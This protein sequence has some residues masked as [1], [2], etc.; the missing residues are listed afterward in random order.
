V[1]L[2]ALDDLGDDIADEAMI[3]MAGSSLGT[4]RDDR[5]RLDARDEARELRA[6]PSEVGE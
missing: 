4:K 6:Q 1:A 3:G 2:V 5:C